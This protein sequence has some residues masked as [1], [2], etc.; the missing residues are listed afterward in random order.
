METR[1]ATGPGPRFAPEVDKAEDLN[2]QAGGAELQHTGVSLGN[3]YSLENSH[4]EVPMM[5]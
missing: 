1:G 3:L 5:F 4:L 2:E